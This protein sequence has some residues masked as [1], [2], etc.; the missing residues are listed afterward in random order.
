MKTHEERY[1]EAVDR[2]IYNSKRNN[3][4]Y[5]GLELSEAKQKLGIRID[6]KRFDEKVKKITGKPKKKK[7]K[8][9]EK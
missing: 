8:K 9:S 7:E 1:N 2:N 4:K 6:D 3:K 5:K